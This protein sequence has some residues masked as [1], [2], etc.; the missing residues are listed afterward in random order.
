MAVQ[1]WDNDP[2]LNITI[3]GINIAEGCPPQNVNN[4]LRSIMAGVRVLYDD[5]PDV[6]GFAPL[7]GPVFT[8]A[9]PI[10]ENE[11][12]FLHHANSSFVSARIHLLPEGSAQPAAASNGDMAFYYAP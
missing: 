8:G 1:D 10:F 4:G 12:A 3:D 5:L 11:G 6:E 2:N 7:A 9:Q